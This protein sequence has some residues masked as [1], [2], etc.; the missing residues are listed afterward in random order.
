VPV[1]RPHDADA[2]I[3]MRQ[4]T[5]LD[6]MSF[7]FS[8]SPEEE[9]EATLVGEVGRLLQ[10]EF[11]AR[12]FTPAKFAGALKSSDAGPMRFLNG[13]CNMRLGELAKVALAMGCVVKVTLEEIP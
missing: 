3:L 6:A 12:K 5:E 13:S 11:I 8:L 2:N 1:R 7:E 9:A 4:G 10:R